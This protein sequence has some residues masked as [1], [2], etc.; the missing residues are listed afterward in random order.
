MPNP[1]VEHFV[2]RLALRLVGHS[3]EA[4]SSPSVLQIVR[5]QF[6]FDAIV[7]VVRAVHVFQQLFAQLEC[8]FDVLRVYQDFFCART[9]FVQLEKHPTLFIFEVVIRGLAFA[10]HFVNVEKGLFHL[11]R[12]QIFEHL[13]V[14]FDD[15][16][17]RCLVEV[18]D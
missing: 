6:I 17:H 18:V 13:V 5:P 9:V 3:I 10:L 15:A 11:F 16:L 12:A 4:L 2:Q 7:H 14:L 8:P 1:V